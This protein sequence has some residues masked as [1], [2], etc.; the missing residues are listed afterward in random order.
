MKGHK[1]VPVGEELKQ[2][3]VIVLSTVVG[4]FFC[5]LYFSVKVKTIIFALVGAAFIVL[6][7]LCTLP[8][9]IKFFR[10]KRR[11]HLIKTGKLIEPAKK[12]YNPNS[13]FDDDY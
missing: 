11:E 7:I 2:S 12:S 8:N 9:L 13:R 4:L 5:L 1:N 3:T 10:G 6:G